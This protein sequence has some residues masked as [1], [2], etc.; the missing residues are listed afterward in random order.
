V[1]DKLSPLEVQM[2]YDISSKAEPAEEGN[3]VSAS[4]T[5]YVCSW[6]LKQSKLVRF[7]NTAWEL[8]CSGWHNLFCKGY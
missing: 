2:R 6:L 4:S 5:F 7:E 1:K 8:A 3:Q